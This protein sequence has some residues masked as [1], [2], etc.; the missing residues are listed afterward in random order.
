MPSTPLMSP[1]SPE[2]YGVLASVFLI[3]GFAAT[4]FFCIQPSGGGEHAPQGRKSPRQGTVQGQSVIVEL[5]VGAIASVFLGFGT[6]FVFLWAGV[7]V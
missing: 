7:W 1:V 2:L 6:L 5:A 3:L 4:A